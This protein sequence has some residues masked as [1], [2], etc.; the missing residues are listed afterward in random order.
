MKMDVVIV[1][2]GAA[3]LM[4]AIQAGLRGRKVLV[5]DHAAKIGEKI[6]ISGGGRCNFTNLYTAPDKFISGNPS[7]CT[8]ALRRYTPTDFIKLVERHG[9]SYHEK[10][11]GQLFC[12]GSATQIV[13]MLLDECAGA[14]VKIS[15]GTPIKNVAKS[16]DGF[17]I[18]T[19][20]AEIKASSLVIATGGLSIPKIGATGFGYDIARQFGIDVVPT[21]AALVP[22]TFT[23]QVRDLTSSLSGVTVDPV[24]AHAQTGPLFR[25]AMVFTHRGLSGPAILQMSSYW[26]A[27]EEITLNL[28]PTQNIFLWLK[29]HRKTHGRQNIITILGELLP[30]RLLQSLLADDALNARLGDVPDELFKN[31]AVNL[32]QWR[33]KPAGDEGYR[34]AEV[35]AGGVDTHAL[36]SKTFGAK[37][38]PNLYFIGEVVDVIGH[39]GGYNF[40][41][42]WSS[43]WC[44]GQ[45]V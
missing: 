17:I 13:Q 29:Q 16:G 8:S 28:S 27:G 3:G 7:F 36:S 40:Q 35:T 43:G 26:R 44:A 14:S 33:L 21:R 18:K 42:A 10:T 32:E 11:L 6:R 41:W 45:Y 2:A 23:D 25:E 12:D 24:L 5:L 39:L 22:L 34:T 31:I 30:R 38:V 20:Q 9:I 4:C 19:D 1:G 37:T 15:Q